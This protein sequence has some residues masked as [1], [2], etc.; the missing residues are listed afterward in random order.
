MI[1]F[2]SGDTAQFAKIW[3]S[4]FGI[5]HILSM[6]M[7]NGSLLGRKTPNRYVLFSMESETE[8]TEEESLGLEQNFEI[9]SLFCCNFM[10][11]I[12][13]FISL[14]DPILA[15]EEISL[16]TRVRQAEILGN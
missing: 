4:T 5:C 12:T 9:F 2:N 6:Q 3:N 14:E 7:I 8:N 11:I 15:S 16:T 1:I 13:K 10:S